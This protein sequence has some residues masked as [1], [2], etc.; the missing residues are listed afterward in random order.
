MLARQTLVIRIRCRDSVLFCI[1]FNI[2]VTSVANWNQTDA[3]EEE[4]RKKRKE[5]LTYIRDR[6]EKWVYV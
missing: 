6:E 5:I 1:S 3:E 4:N 2:E